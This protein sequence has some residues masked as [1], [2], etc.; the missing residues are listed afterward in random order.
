MQS[1][2]N[3][4]RL[5]GRK[6]TTAKC[7]FESFP[8]YW[9][10]AMHQRNKIFAAFNENQKSDLASWIQMQ[11]ADSSDKIPDE[12]WAAYFGC[13]EKTW[14]RLISDHFLPQPKEGERRKRFAFV[15]FVR[16]KAE[17][18]DSSGNRAHLNAYSIAKTK[19]IFYGYN[20]ISCS[21]WNGC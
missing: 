13:S 16:P 9:P 2:E 6:P 11:A 15:P 10:H 1:T 21:K 12:K 5:R 19:V 17:T 4:A 18:P 14:F 8:D 7:T 3:G 20:C